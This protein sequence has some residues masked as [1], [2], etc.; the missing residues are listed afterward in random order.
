MDFDPQIFNCPI[1]TGGNISKWKNKFEGGVCFQIY[2]CAD[3]SGGFLNPRPTDDTLSE[4][5]AQS[6]HGINEP[7]SCDAV[8]QAEKEFPNSI[9]DARRIVSTCGGLIENAENSADR[10]TKGPLQAIGYWLWIW[11]LLPVRHQGGLCRGLHK[12]GRL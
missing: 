8:L 7:V 2:I 3:C 10:L 12:S 6:G 5:Y 11:V 4:I 9:V 1:C